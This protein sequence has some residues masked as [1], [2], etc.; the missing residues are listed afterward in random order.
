MFLEACWQRRTVAGVLEVQE[1]LGLSHIVR[2]LAGER[3]GG[4]KFTLFYEQETYGILI[5]AETQVVLT[6]TL[7]TRSLGGMQA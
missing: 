2:S 4:I 6:L 3:C 5:H 1:E 7:G